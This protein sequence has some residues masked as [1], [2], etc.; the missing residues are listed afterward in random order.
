MDQ[1][2]LSAEDVLVSAPP[3]H[4]Y[5]RKS[6]S[7]QPFAKDAAEGTPQ[8]PLTDNS[9]STSSSQDSSAADLADHPHTRTLLAM[10][11]RSSLLGM[12]ASALD[13]PS[14]SNTGSLER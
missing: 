2:F 7:F 3:R 13:F 8:S 1:R 6:T 4:L 12:E 11:S 14:G 10:S 9:Y 5:L